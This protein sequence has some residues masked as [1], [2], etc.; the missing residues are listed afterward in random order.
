MNLSA[1]RWAKTVFPIFGLF[2]L[3]WFLFRVIPKPS[4]AT[5]PCMRVAFPMASTFVVWLV[6]AWNFRFS[7]PQSKKKHP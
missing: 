4:R 2:S 5:Y 1:S 7:G 6:R 3:I